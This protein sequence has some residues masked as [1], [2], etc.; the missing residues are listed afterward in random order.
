MANFDGLKVVIDELKD[1]KS[2]EIQLQKKQEVLSLADSLMKKVKLM[3]TELKEDKSLLSSKLKEKTSSILLL[4]SEMKKILGNE[5]YSTLIDAVK[6]KIENEEIQVTENKTI[7][8]IVESFQPKVIEESKVDVVNNVNEA[9]PVDSIEESTPTIV[10]DTNTT[11][12]DV[13]EEITPTIVEDIAPVVV[14]EEN[15]K[16]NYAES[17]IAQ[18]P[19][20]VSE[21]DLNKIKSLL[22]TI[23]EALIWAESQN[24]LHV[25]E[26]LFLSY[27]YLDNILSLLTDE[28]FTTLPL[29][30]SNKVVNYLSSLPQ[31]SISEK[32][33]SDMQSETINEHQRL[34]NIICGI[35]TLLNTTTTNADNIP[36]DDNSSSTATEEVAKEEVLP[37]KEATEESTSVD[38]KPK[39]KRPVFGRPVLKR[40]SSV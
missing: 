17:Y 12:V 30:I 39:V 26:D 3:T 19:N 28:K 32:S 9:A 13:V 18:I 24:T 29:S 35:D 37:T 11:P 25:N 8:E 7:Y 21:E 27:L 20:N 5:M 36:F 38:D 2:L 15:I 6:V 31:Y 40:T 10:E 1:K 16:T 4:E 23:N 33:V 14:E 22:N 34:I